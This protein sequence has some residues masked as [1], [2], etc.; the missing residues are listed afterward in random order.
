MRAASVAYEHEYKMVLFLVQRSAGKESNNF[1]EKKPIAFTQ[2]LR[3]MDDFRTS[4]YIEQKVKMN[5][6]SFMHLLK[7]PN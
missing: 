2:F 1:G 6:K 3:H 5:V 4:M 7:V